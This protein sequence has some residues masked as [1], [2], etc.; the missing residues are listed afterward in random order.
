[1]ASLVVCCILLG[2]GVLDPCHFQLVPFPIAPSCRLW[3]ISDRDGNRNREESFREQALQCRPVIFLDT[4]PDSSHKCQTGGFFWKAHT[5]TQFLTQNIICISIGFLKIV[6]T[7][8]LF[9]GAH[10]SFMLRVGQQ[11]GNCLDKLYG[12][13]YLFIQLEKGFLMLN[14]SAC[15][16]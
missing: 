11:T 9:K 14:F 1:M 16:S 8:I 4:I 7:R 5:Q 6:L 10:I 15:T 3:L 13:T 2:G 12:S